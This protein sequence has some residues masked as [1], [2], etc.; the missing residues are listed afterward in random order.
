M[1]IDHD[2]MTRSVVLED[3]GT[4][5]AVAA[6]GRLLDESTSEAESGVPG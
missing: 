6:A 3:T 2:G 1:V 5:Q 4:E